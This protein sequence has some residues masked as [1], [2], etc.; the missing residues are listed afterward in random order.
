[1]PATKHDIN[2]HG[3]K[4]PNSMAK[5][6]MDILGDWQIFFFLGIAGLF[7]GC[8]FLLI[9]FI[10]LV[11]GAGSGV[12]KLFLLVLAPLA[13]TPG[14]ILMF[15]GL[16]KRKAAK[17]LENLAELL[18]AYRRIKISK[19]AQ[20][21]GVTEYEAEMKI[22]ACLDAGLVKGHIDRTTDEFFTLESLGQVIPVGGCRNCGAP[23]DRLFLVGEQVK[24]GSCGATLSVSK[25]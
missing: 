2:Q 25:P 21:L 17:N 3:I 7:F 18:R 4:V 19:V 11:V 5:G 15:L 10:L 24:C 20:K 1:M 8:F 23:P 16:R 6:P 12:W 14:I 9:G 13:L 22:A